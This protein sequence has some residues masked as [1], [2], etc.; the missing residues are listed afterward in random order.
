MSIWKYYHTRNPNQNNFG[1]SYYTAYILKSLNTINMSVMSHRCVATLI[2]CYYLSFSL[3]T[4]LVFMTCCCVQFQVFFKRFFLLP[5]SV[6]MNTT[7]IK[8]VIG[9]CI[10]KLYFTPICIFIW[11][12][13]SLSH[14]VPHP[15]SSQM[16]TVS[17]GHLRP[18]SWVC[19]SLFWGSVPREGKLSC[20]AGQRGQWACSLGGMD[21]AA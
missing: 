5:M 11:V 17:S 9:I 18:A 13:H 12:P 20:T 16:L 8:T 19:H 4:K 21:E 1:I 3:T 15:V 7:A 14:R 6:I 10:R 2:T